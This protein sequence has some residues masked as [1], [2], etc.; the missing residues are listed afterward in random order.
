MAHYDCSNCG[1]HLGI[2]FGSC[3]RCTPR[4]YHDLCKERNRVFAAA[5]VRFEEEEAGVIAAYEKAVATYEAYRRSSIGKIAAA[6][7]EGID[8]RIHEIKMEKYHSYRYDHEKKLK[9]EN[10]A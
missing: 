6:E 2:D 9:K 4:E 7:A 1:A 3:H 5:R 10:K 8:A